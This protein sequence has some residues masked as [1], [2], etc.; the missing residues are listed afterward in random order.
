MILICHRPLLVAGSQGQAISFI[1][2]EEERALSNIEKLIGE[3]ITRIK[4]PGYSVGNRV[5]WQKKGPVLN[6]TE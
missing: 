2:R 5:I 6:R 1:S 4:R 3:R